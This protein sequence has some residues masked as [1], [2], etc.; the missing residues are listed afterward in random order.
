MLKCLL[1]NQLFMIFD[2]VIVDW[3][4]IK[5]RITGLI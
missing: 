4:A 1:M 3:L 5:L 2:L